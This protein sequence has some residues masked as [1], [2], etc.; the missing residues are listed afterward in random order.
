MTH[1]ANAWLKEPRQAIEEADLVHLK[2]DEAFDAAWITK[3]DVRESC[4]RQA[5]AFLKCQGGDKKLQKKPLTGE[6]LADFHRAGTHPHKDDMST[7]Y[8]KL[9]VS[10][11]LID[12]LRCYKPLNISG[13]DPENACVEH[14]S[15]RLQRR[16]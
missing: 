4:E 10:D 3:E 2:A 16:S 13:H 7:I 6:T 9:K 1:R 14:V 15:H 11:H 5:V 8:A 12:I